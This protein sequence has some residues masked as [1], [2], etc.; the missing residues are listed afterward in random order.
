MYS[1]SNV[2]V[3]TDNDL[4]GAGAHKATYIHPQDKTLCVKIARNAHDVDLKRELAYRSI[5]AKQHKI[6]T[7]MPI[8]APLRL[9]RALVISLSAFLIVIVKPAS[10]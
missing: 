3:L 2:L 1:S 8:M 5:I 9:T 6:P 4:I 7:L 10:L